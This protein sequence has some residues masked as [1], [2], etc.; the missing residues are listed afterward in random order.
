M[1]YILILFL[2]FPC[3]VNLARQASFK[4]NVDG[5]ARLQQYIFRSKPT[6]FFSGKMSS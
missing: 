5:N 1:K 6:Q 3:Y 4:S 2:L